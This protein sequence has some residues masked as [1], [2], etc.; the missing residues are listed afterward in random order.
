MSGN[1]RALGEG[2]GFFSKREVVRSAR[3]LRKGRARILH[4][5]PLLYAVDEK[6]KKILSVIT[7][8]PKT[9]Q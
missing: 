4:N 6:H 1:R 8:E 3:L 2:L 5:V 9:K 7:I